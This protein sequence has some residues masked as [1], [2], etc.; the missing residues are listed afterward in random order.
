VAASLS[1][2]PHRYEAHVTLHAPEP[3]VRARTR[4]LWG[5][6]E[7]ID[8]ASCAY[9]TGDDSLDWL[10]MRIGMLGV[11]FDVHAPDELA[12]RCRELSERFAHAAAGSSPIA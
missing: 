7:P 8:D 10:A 12:G 6:L 9:R 4:Y 11:P 2:T 5:T 1:G 3:E